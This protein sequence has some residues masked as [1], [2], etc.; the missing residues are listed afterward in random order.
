MVDALDA[1]DTLGD[2]EVRRRAGWV[3]S[4]IRQGWDLGEL[5]A[6][7]RQ[8]DARHARWERER[9]ERDRQ[10]ARWRTSEVASAGWRAAVSAALDDRQLAVAVERVTTPVAGLDRRSVPIVRA[11]LVAWAVAA[12]RT[13]PDRPLPEVLADDL[14]GSDR[15]VGAPSFEGPLP[16]SPSAMAGREDDLGARLTDLLARRADLARPGPRLTNERTTP[17][18]ARSRRGSDMNDDVARDVPRNGG[19]EPVVSA[20]EAREFRNAIEYTIQLTFVVGGA[21]WRTAHAR[22]R[23]IAER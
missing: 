23:R 2:R 15:T 1:V 11:Q 22:A 12:H 18:S 7:R 8:I 17:V 9:D 14:V 13:A 5:L 20:H 16:P 10:A 21:R 6:E 19:R 4:A 3:V